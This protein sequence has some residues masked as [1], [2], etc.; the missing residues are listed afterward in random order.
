MERGGRAPTGAAPRPAMH[1]APDRA[2][3]RR[4]GRRL[5]AR[6][7][8]P[9]STRCSWRG[10]GAGTDGRVPGGRG[11]PRPQPAGGA[12]DAVAGGGPVLALC[13]DV[14]RR[15]PGLR[16]RVG[17]FTLAAT[18]SSRPIRAR[19]SPSPTS[20][21]ST[22][23]PARP[24]TAPSG[25]AP[26]SRRWPGASPRCASRRRCSSMSTRCAR[27]RVAL[28]RAAGPRPGGGAE[29]ELLLRGEGAPRALPAPRGAPVAG[30]VR[31]RAGGAGARSAGARSPRSCA[32][33]TRPV[34]GVQVLF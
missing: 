12:V 10:L 24:P 27:A 15:L 22:R 21:R 7:R 32:D 5:S 33:R 3:G 29:L 1:A 9:R 31:A 6:Q 23:R 8:W 4:R 16:E 19:R 13:A 17:G 25:P 28:P 20:S 2:P 14:S 30:A 18:A 26:G 11:L 34:A